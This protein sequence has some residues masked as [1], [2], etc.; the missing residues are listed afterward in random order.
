MKIPPFWAKET[1]SDTDPKGRKHSFIATGWS[2]TSLDEAKANAIE[3]AK[4]IFDFVTNGRSPC[5]YEDYLDQ[6]VRE[7]ILEEIPNSDKQIGL[8]TRNRYGSLVLNTAQVA[9]V[10]V[11][12]PP[13][14]SSG[15][16]EWIVWL[17]QP[18][19]KREKQKAL[20]DN[21]QQ[22][23][24]DWAKKN[25]A[26]G[27]RLYRTCA[28]FRLLFTDRLYIPTGPETTRLLEELGSDRLYRTLTFKQE[29]FRARLTPKPWRCN[30][31]RPGIYFPWATPDHEK[32][33]RAWEQIYK[34]ASSGYR[35]C[36]M[37]KQY[38]PHT[39]DRV[40][41]KII[42]IHDLRACGMPQQ[43]LA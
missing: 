23:I 12:F 28:G 26:R 40:I 13:L 33:Y 10:D 20:Q 6:P 38:G 7:E 9:F 17:F 15:L 25:P 4:K 34:K 31:R 41:Q 5:T 29:C 43:P 2:F 27:F 39:S 32:K 35:T 42:D 24:D 14:Y 8:I 30:C 21:T 11:D 19:K 37:I 18:S 22:T 1:F 3:R 16:K 36:D